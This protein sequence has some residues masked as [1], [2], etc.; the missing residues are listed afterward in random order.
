[1]H[2]YTFAFDFHPRSK[3]GRWTTAGYAQDKEHSPAID[4]GDP[5]APVG[6]EPKPNGHRLNLGRYG[7]TAEASLMLTDGTILLVQQGLDI[8]SG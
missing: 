8:V 6:A 2:T 1:M 4:A 7:G 3:A 5:S